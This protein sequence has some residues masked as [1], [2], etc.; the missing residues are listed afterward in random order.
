MLR[1]RTGLTPRQVS[2]GAVITSKLLK[3]GEDAWLRHKTLIFRN[4]FLKHIEAQ[5]SMLQVE[6]VPSDLLPD[7]M[8]CKTL[9]IGVVPAIAVG[10]ASSHSFSSPIQFTHGQCTENVV[11]PFESPTKIASSTTPNASN[12]YDLSDSLAAR[13]NRNKRSKTRPFDFGST[14]CVDGATDDPLSVRLQFF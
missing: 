3:L 1:N 8:F 7:E 2:R 11:T 10:D 5:S 13:I 12:I 9:G 6:P 4:S 14:S